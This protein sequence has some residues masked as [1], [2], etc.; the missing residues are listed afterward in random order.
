[1]DLTILSIL[2]LFP[3]RIDHR[4]QFFGFIYTPMATPSDFPFGFTDLLR[5]SHFSPIFRYSRY[6]PLQ[7]RPEMTF[8]GYVYR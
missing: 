2:G 1:M 8:G 5:L 6:W 4:P 3:A 7:N